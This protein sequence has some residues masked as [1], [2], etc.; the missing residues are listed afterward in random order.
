VCIVRREPGVCRFANIKSGASEEYLDVEFYLHAPKFYG[1]V[2]QQKS[3]Q[4]ILTCIDLYIYIYIYIYIYSLFLTEKARKCIT[5]AKK[6]DMS[7]KVQ[8][9]RRAIFK[10]LTAKI[11][12]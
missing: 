9:Y 11:S 2:I 10:F 7:R 6:S 3:I 12:Y 8:C 4:F 1:L 5:F